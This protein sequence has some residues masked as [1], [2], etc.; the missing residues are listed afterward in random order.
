MF[1]NTSED[2][3]PEYMKHLKYIV[4]GAAPLGEKTEEKFLDK[5]GRHLKIFQGK[6]LNFNFVLS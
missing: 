6:F 3:K 4:N 1:L 5:A 2:V